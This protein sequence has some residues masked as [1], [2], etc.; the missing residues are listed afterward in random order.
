[1]WAH[2]PQQSLLLKLHAGSLLG[3]PSNAG[4][5]SGGAKRV[6]AEWRAVLG[7]A[8]VD[9][10]LLQVALSGASSTAATPPTSRRDLSAP[11][12]GG[13][14]GGGV[15]G[16]GSG[17]F[18]GG[19][20]PPVRQEL[21]V[22]C[23]RSLFVVAARTGELLLQR[24]LE[25][26]PA[27][28]WP[29]PAAA[30]APGDGGGRG[31]LSTGSAGSD[32][33]GGVSEKEDS[34]LVATHTRGMLVYQGP[35][36]AW[37]ARLELQPVALRV[38]DVGGARGMIVALDDTGESHM[39]AG[40]LAGIAMPSGPSTCKW[41]LFD[42]VAVHVVCGGICKGCRFPLHRC[43]LNPI[44]ILGRPP[45]GTVPGHRSPEPRCGARG[46]RQAA[47]LCGHGR[48]APAA[49]GGDAGGRRRQRAA[50]VGPLALYRCQLL[51]DVLAEAAAASNV[52]LKR[53][54]SET[55][56][57]LC[58]HAYGIPK[59]PSGP[60]HEMRPAAWVSSHGDRGPRAPPGRLCHGCNA[61]AG[62]T[63]SRLQPPPIPAPA[64]EDAAA[65]AAASGAGR[66]VIQAH[67]PSRL[68]PL[69]GE[70]GGGRGGT[71]AP[72]QVTARLLLSHSS[73]GD[74]KV[75]ALP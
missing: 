57:C 14:G 60:P 33:G 3:L 34:L 42:M 49:A 45:F 73:P 52:A 13:G 11:A 51:G 28:C 31:P 17:L 61:M 48:G 68:D 47:G 5:Q 62:R 26:H 29:Y 54:I 40:P 75:G 23:E 43:A 27:C 6:Q 67:V 64:Q 20:P 66:L 1:M 24:R 32:V 38:A 12:F 69:T 2:H 39:Q 18:G 19:G 25:Y 59:H 9:I 36:L 37:A 44:S 70:G 4:A 10:C 55:G 53:G 63:Q 30:S 72:R 71:A 22:L 35:A 21:L 8:A 7:E 65:A 74:L 56:R 15:M 16:G 46:R 41:G 58:C 50:G